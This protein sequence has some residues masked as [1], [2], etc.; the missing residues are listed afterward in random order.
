MEWTRDMP[1]VDGFYWFKRQ[2]GSCRPCIAEVLSGVLW[3]HGA[4]ECTNLSRLDDG[5]CEWFG[6]LVEPEGFTVEP[7]DEFDAGLF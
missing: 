4:S 5:T 6:P 3:L 7:R 2:G 1:T